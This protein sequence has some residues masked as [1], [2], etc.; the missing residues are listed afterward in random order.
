MA[1]RTLNR[2]IINQINNKYRTPQSTQ[3]RQINAIHLNPANTLIHEITKCKKCYELLRNNKMF[4]TEAV[5]QETN[6]RHDIVCL[7]NNQVIEIVNTNV[8]P[9]ILKHYEAKKYKII[10]CRD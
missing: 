2:Y 5:N 6:E 3:K 1:N 8:S 4:I 9:D 7:S 10:Y